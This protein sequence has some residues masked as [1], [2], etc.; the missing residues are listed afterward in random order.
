MQPRAEIR[1]GMI[2]TDVLDPITA[3]RLFVMQALSEANSVLRKF[4]RETER[5]RRRCA[6]V[7]ALLTQPFQLTRFLVPG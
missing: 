4:S 7:N 1:A 3:I 2:S 6:A 5:F